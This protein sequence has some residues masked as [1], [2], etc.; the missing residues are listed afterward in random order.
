MAARNS[1]SGARRP[2]LTR[3][4]LH[5]AVA[6]VPAAG[7]WLSHQVALALA[8][9]LFVASGLVELA[10]RCWPGLNRLLWRLLP[11][12][13]RTWED[14]RLLGSTWLGL[15]VLATLL[16]F[17]RDAGGT[18]VLFAVWGD[19]AAE[20]AGRA[21]GRPGQ[22]KTWAGSLGCLLACL[23]AALVGV[24]LG[25]L[26]PWPVLAG[27]LVATAVERWSPPPDDNVWMPLL[28]GLAIVVAAMLG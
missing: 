10:R 3:K 7:W 8:A 9:A 22:R 13:F 19:S 6:L 16:L 11:S 2:S 24:G 1:D 18:A 4:L 21:F 15:G 23:L 17:G 12:T 28:G 14:R 26:A 5:L 27:A 20:L 25:G